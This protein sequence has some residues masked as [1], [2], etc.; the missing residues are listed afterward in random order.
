MARQPSRIE[1]GALFRASDDF[2]HVWR[3]D[4]FLTDEVHVALVRVD[5]PSRRKTLSLWALKHSRLFVPVS[6]QQARHAE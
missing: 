1:H 4:K 5:D 2:R 3:V 6:T